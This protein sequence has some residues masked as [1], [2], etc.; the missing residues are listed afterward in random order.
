MNGLVQWCF[1]FVALLKNKFVF[2]EIE[3]EKKRNMN[4][5]KAHLLLHQSGTWTLVTLHSCHHFHLSISDKKKTK[6]ERK[7]RV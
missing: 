6:P 3:F 4:S 7:W 2:S 1:L 5:D